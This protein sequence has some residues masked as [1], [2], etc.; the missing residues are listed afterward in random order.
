METH[1]SIGAEVAD[2]GQG[3]NELGRSV[4]DGDGRCSVFV[5]LPGR[6]LRSTKPIKASVIIHTVKEGQ[7]VEQERTVKRSTTTVATGR[8]LLEGTL[9]DPDPL[10][11]RFERTATIGPLEMTISVEVK[12]EISACAKASDC[13]SSSIK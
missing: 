10:E 11:P 1:N 7:A 3:E 4:G 9:T 2:V 6:A 13:Q 8:L 5:R 12:V